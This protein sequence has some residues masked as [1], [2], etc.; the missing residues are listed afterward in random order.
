MRAKPLRQ[1]LL[2]ARGH[3]LHALSGA[4]VSFDSDKGVPKRQRLPEG[5]S[6]KNQSIHLGVH[7]PSLLYPQPDLAGA[8][9]DYLLIYMGRY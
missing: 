5:E 4:I 1:L 6:C 8:K 7:D 2:K 3:L 9:S